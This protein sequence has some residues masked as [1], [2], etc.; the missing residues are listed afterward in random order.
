MGGIIIFLQNAKEREK[1]LITPHIRH[2]SES[3][4]LFQNTYNA[5]IYVVTT[6]LIF[7]LC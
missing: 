6:H 2:Y 3:N 1:H 7:H 4:I 5:F